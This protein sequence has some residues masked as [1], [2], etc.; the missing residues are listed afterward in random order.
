MSA[1]SCHFDDNAK[2]LKLFSF[3]FLFDC[4]STLLYDIC[5]K[6]IL[7]RSNVGEKVFIWLVLSGLN[8]S[9]G[10]VRAVSSEGNKVETILLICLITSSVSHAQLSFSYSPVP[11]TYAVCHTI[12]IINQTNN[13]SMWP[14]TNLIGTIS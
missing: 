10:K 2:V 4:F 7:V 12:R 5:D 13:S 1:N 9:K 3:Y 11:A 14:H 6:N 8:L